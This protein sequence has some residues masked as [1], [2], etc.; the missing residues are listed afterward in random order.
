MATAGT[1]VSA[2]TAECDE[3]FAFNYCFNRRPLK[4]IPIKVYD[5][6]KKATFKQALEKKLHE[7]CR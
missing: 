1:D 5:S 4:Y 3:Y 6:T 7:N 2:K